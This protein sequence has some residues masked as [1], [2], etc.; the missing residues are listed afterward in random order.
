[1]SRRLNQLIRSL[2]ESS[3][4]L[5]ESAKTSSNTADRNTDIIADQKQ[6]IDQVV[7]AIEEMSS[8]IQEVVGHAAESATKSEQG[9]EEAEKGRDTVK[10]TVSAVDELAANLGKSMEVIKDLEK[11]SN[12]IG[13]VI[14]VIQGISEQTNLL[15]LNAAIEA[16]RA[17]EQGRGFA[18]VA[19][20]VR[21]LAKRTQESTTEIQA[22][23][24]NLQQGTAESVTAMVRCT[25][26]ASETVKSSNTTDAALASLHELIS[27][28]SSMNIQVA[29][30][31]EQQSVVAEDI[32]RNLLDISNLTEE[33][34]ASASQARSG[35]MEVKQ[36]AVELNKMASTFK[37]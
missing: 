28:I 32:N 13:S 24:Q 21:S 4:V 34:M 12:E 8:S 31:V 35:S 20:E 29:T 27:D 10:T 33:T 23:I 6:R 25:E 19:D 2:L 3:H 18:V 30:A 15:A 7:V 5:I 9:L 37:V 16:A 17:G 11:Q 1:M 14:E 22:I 26:Q 36:M